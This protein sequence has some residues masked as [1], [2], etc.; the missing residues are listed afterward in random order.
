MIAILFLFLVSMIPI[1]G[2]W[3]C[4]QVFRWLVKRS[5]GAEVQITPDNYFDMYRNMKT[6]WHHDPL[7]YSAGTQADRRKSKHNPHFERIMDKDN[8]QRLASA[9]QR[10][11]E[12]TI[13]DSQEVVE[14][15]SLLNNK[16]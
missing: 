7:D 8:A 13:D 12:Q 5:T 16:S 10:I 2:V 4:I 3:L 6:V 14:L 1:M 11:S 9:R 15:A